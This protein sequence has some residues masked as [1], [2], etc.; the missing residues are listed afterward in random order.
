METGYTYQDAVIVSD[1]DTEI[2]LSWYLHGS[3]MVFIV[4]LIN[5]YHGI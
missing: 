5:K 4:T 2:N 1:D 3:T